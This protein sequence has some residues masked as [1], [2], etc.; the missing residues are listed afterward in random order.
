MFLVARLPAQQLELIKKTTVERKALT[1]AEG[2]AT[3]FGSAVNGRSHQQ[4][5]ITTYRGYQ[6]VTYFDAERRVCIARRKLP[7]GAWQIIQFKDHLFETNDSHNTAVLGI[8]DK[9]GTIHMAFDHHATRL[10]YRVSKLGAA[11]DPDSVR[12]T[13]DL[14]G[15]KQ[16]TLGSVKPDKKVTYPRFFSAS[17]G[18]LMLYYRAVTSAN[19]HGMIEEYDGDRHDWTPGLGKFISRDIGTYTVAGKTSR[20]RCPY[21]NSLSYAGDRLHASWVWRD[22]FEKT[23]PNNQHDLCYA[24]SDDH[25]RTWHNSRGKFIGKTRKDPIHLNSPGLVVLPIPTGSNLSN[26]NTHYAYPDGSIHLV[27]IQ[28]SE[29]ARGRRYHHYWRTSEGEWGSEILPFSGKRP[30]LVGAGDRSLVLVYTRNSQLHAAIGVAYP[31]QYKWKWVTVKLPERHSCY[32]EALLD[33]ERWEQDKVLS[34]YSQEEPSRA[35]RTRS[36]KPVDGMPSP[37]NVVDYRFTK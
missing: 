22:R 37:L 5:P 17:N 24:Y 8:C 26:Q 19:G 25:G 30:K 28:R 13:V 3:R 12:W 1:F 14:F 9:D 32:G 33:L 18:N 4:S 23:H 10:N 29:G 35:V 20:F 21:M 34:I 36:S 16:H 31:D 11:H 2:S 27:M 7:S 6:Y 15:K